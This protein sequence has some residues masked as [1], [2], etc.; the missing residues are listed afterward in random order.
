MVRLAQRSSDREIQSGIGGDASN[1]EPGP[2]YND[3]L[4]LFVRDL[5]NPAQAAE[6]SDSLGR[7]LRAIGR[8]A[9]A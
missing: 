5:W 9:D 4:E 3:Y 1:N 7:A 8:L 6:R 2:I